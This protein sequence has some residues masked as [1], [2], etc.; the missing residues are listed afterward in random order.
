[1]SKGTPSMGKKNKRN[2]LMCP[3]CGNMAYHKQKR[4]CASCAFPEAKKRTPAS[5]KAARRTGQGVGNMKY[6]KREMKR[7]KAGHK[8]NPIL[9]GLKN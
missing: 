7:A 8:G 4:A 1:M 5:L 9:A 6:M 3:R 2:H